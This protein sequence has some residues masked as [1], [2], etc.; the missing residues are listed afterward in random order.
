MNDKEAGPRLR[1]ST[2]ERAGGD[3]TPERWQKIKEL[4]LAAQ[5]VDTA[6]RRE[7]LQE[8]CG[9]DHDLRTEIESLLAAAGGESELS[10]GPLMEGVGLGSATDPMVGRRLGAYEI[11]RQI[12]RGGMAMVYLA[13][14]AD[15]AY[16][17]QVAIK[18]VP[19]GTDNAE[20]LS[21][22]RN[23]RQTLAALDHPNIVRLIDG[24]S[25]SEGVPYL[26]M[27]FV[28]GAPID[29]YC[30]RHRLSIEQRLHLFHSICRAVHYAHQHLVVH[31]DLK[32][33]NILVT[34]EG[35]PKLLDFGIAKV[36]SPDASQQML[37]TQTQT[38]RMT[39]AYA[40]PEQVRGDAVTPASD[41]YSLGVVLYE[42][43]TGH[44]PY[45]LKQSTPAE[46]EHAICEQ[47]PESPSTAVDRIE[48]ET[49][50]DGTIVTKTPES[51]SKTREGVPE[52]LRQRLRGDLDKIV[53]M[54]LRKDSQRR[55]TSALELA[56][57]LQRHLGHLPV[58]A[59]PL[60]L[61][62]RAS[63]FVRRRRTELMA[64]FLIISVLLAS[65]RFSVWQVRRA[66]ER[67]RAEADNLHPRAR[68]SVAVLGFKN[69]SGLAETAWVSTALA[70]LL[71]TELSL[72]GALRTIPGEN[73]ALAKMNL[74]LSEQDSL[75]S[76]A[77]NRLSRSLGSDYLVLGSYLDTGGSARSIRVDVRMHNGSSHDTSSLSVEAGTDTDLVDLIQHIGAQL[78]IKLG[79]GEVTAAEL[80]T[81]KTALPSN[82]DAIRFYAEGLAKL[83]TLDA[84]EARDRLENAVA[85]D[86]NFALAH[87]ALSEAWASL[88]YD[89]KAKQEAERAFNLSANLPREN[90]LWIE[91]RYRDTTHEL[92]RVAQIYQA[93]FEFFPDNIEY[94]LK[95]AATQQRAGQVHQAQATINALRALPSP[96]R[97]DPRIDWL[98]AR[99]I[100]TLEAFERV[101]EKLQSSGNRSLLAQVL[102]KES[103]LQRNAG[104][105]AQALALLEK[106][107]E[108]FRLTGNVNGSALAMADVAGVHWMQ[109]DPVATRQ[110]AEESLA[111]YRKT[112]DQEGIARGLSTVGLALINAG[113]LRG[114]K[115]ALTESLA[116]CR[117]IRFK[118]GITNNLNNLSTIAAQVGDLDEARGMAEEV[119]EIYADPQAGGPESGG[120]V[121]A[122]GNI[123]EDLF[124]EGEVAQA[125][126]LSR[127]ALNIS[128][129]H[130][131][132]NLIGAL[133]SILGE[134]QMAQDDFPKARRNLEEGRAI[135]KK[136]GLQKDEADT[137]L[138]LARLA[139]E[140]ARFDAA[141]KLTS[142]AA[143]K[144]RKENS[145]ESA[146]YADALLAQSFLSQQ[147]VRDARQAL[148]HC[149][150]LPEQAMDVRL[151]LAI[152]SA[153]VR[154]SLNQ[155]TNASDVKQAAQILKTALAEARR[156]GYLVYQ[157]EAR[158]AL[159]E[160]ELNTGNAADGRQQLAALEKEARSKGFLLIARKAASIVQN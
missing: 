102:L 119:R 10:T 68:R 89:E 121:M 3:P 9:S 104:A 95:L 135:D 21:R 141:E 152:A 58:R 2:P 88:G 90:R 154:M 47:D 115:K 139:I 157:F 153:R 143:L 59:R 109:G 144:F 86:P 42:L 49:L 142:A 8:A 48:N 118:A 87:S 44:R 74:G 97:D 94:G 117:E 16:R 129:K 67:A 34:S 106:A 25:T 63:K 96:L 6:A 155:Y 14:R 138:T 108:I 65:A 140:E 12:G 100:G 57:D 56:E 75:S 33:S 39:P 78:R 131:Y 69:S 120:V 32:P 18:L 81:V 128:S 15:D 72:G 134:I 111:L 101:A 156:H 22:F 51:V 61:S 151:P 149:L 36:L 159:A 26:V 132:Q 31:R 17:K 64:A 70:E 7:F 122:M 91:A 35:V 41:I 83:R 43:L 137:E 71:T 107:K 82:P 112:G 4:V 60:T 45:K 99:A 133:H 105:M 46:L 66:S 103:E 146:K 1:R 148:S 54:A 13:T 114:A 24:G 38:R 19:P 150:P 92:E 130:N 98:E 23:E 84:L 28:E 147:R 73:V 77:L 116:I 127:Q 113:D 136:L 50:A 52:R 160:I 110:A 30:D 5:E 37:V 145:P 29:E 11:V 62:Y 124:W 93:L 27:D 76:E 125:E 40:S 20:I 123:A 79:N 80:G 53:L 126:R 55:Y 158:L 85:L